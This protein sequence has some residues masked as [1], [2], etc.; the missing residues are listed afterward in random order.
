[1][2]LLDKDFKYLKSI[3]NNN[4]HLGIETDLNPGIYYLL[5]DVNYRYVNENGKNRGYKVTC[6]SKNPILIENVTER[7]DS[8]KA[9]E[10]CMYYYCKE[11]VQPI[12][13]KTGMDIYISKNYN[14]EIP[15]LVACFVNNSPQNY[16]IKL[17]MKPKGEKSFCI[18][19]DS[20][21]T[22]NDVQVIKEIKSGSVKVVSIMKYSL[23]SMFSLSYAVLSS[24][25]V[26]TTETIN[27]VFEEEGEQIDEQG[28]LFQYVKEVDGGDGYTVGL[29]NTSNYKIKLKLVLEGMTIL[30]SEFKGKDSAEF[31]SMPRSKKVFNLKIKPDADDLTFEFVYA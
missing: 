3:S 15:F 24:D 5:C 29:E 17:E 6:Y 19:N 27:P 10:V 22:E 21:A 4:M 28:Y 18:Y 11:K 7:I 1:M 25:D 9:L 13:H 14:S 20:I 8:S 31:M 23:S 30:D 26:R 12:K 16:K 2:I